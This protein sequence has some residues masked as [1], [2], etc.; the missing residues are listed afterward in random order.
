MYSGPL[1]KNGS[2]CEIM[3][4]PKWVP[5]TKK[6]DAVELRTSYM[7][8]GIRTER[9]EL[10]YSTSSHRRMRHKH[11]HQRTCSPP[12]S[13]LPFCHSRG[14]QVRHCAYQ[15]EKNRVPRVRQNVPRVRKMFMHMHMRSR[16]DG[17]GCRQND[18][19]KDALT[20]STAHGGRL[21]T[22]I[23]KL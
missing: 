10:C 4:V 11:Q 20:K 13:A 9:F 17:A 23:E 5:L 18:D 2:W 8:A 7:R 19:T 1:G 6:I 15:I 3:K 22:A 16:K 14:Q 21:R 12:R